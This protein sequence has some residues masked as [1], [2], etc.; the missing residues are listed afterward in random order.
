MVA[1]L[2]ALNLDTLDF[3]ASCPFRPLRIYVVKGDVR[4]NTLFRDSSG[5]ASHYLSS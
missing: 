5:R 2:S 4:S 1:A 3:M